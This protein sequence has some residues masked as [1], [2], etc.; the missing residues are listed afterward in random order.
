MMINIIIKIQVTINN[1][2]I[3]IVKHVNHVVNV[4]KLLNKII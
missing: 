3:G 4:I 1:I 2:L